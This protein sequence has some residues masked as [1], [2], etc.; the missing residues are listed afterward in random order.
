[1]KVKDRVQLKTN[2]KQGT[3]RVIDVLNDYAYVVFPRTKLQMD[4]FRRFHDCEPKPELPPTLH[5]ITDLVQV[6]Q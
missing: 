3:G 2:P 5:L 1:M 6:E 4:R